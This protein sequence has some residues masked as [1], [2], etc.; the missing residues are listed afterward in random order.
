MSTQSLNKYRPKSHFQLDEEK[1]QNSRVRMDSMVLP[2]QMCSESNSSK[3]GHF[4]SEFDL[5]ERKFN[6]NIVPSKD[7]QRLKST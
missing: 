3:R 1:E 4:Q 6:P 7:D 2:K 5:K